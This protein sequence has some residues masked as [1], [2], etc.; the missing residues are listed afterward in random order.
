MLDAESLR[1]ESIQN[2]RRPVAVVL[3]QSNDGNLQVQ[4]VFH[5]FAYHFHLSLSTVGQY[6]VGQFTLFFQNTGIAAAYHLLHGCIIVGTHYR[7]MR[8]LR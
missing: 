6:Q 5:D 2:L 3:G 7:L 1:R 8:Y 4:F